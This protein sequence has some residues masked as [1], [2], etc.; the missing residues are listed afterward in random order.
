MAC[1]L[2]ET[3]LYLGDWSPTPLIRVSADAD[4]PCIWSKLEFMNP[5][6][7][8]KDRIASHILTKAYRSGVIAPGGTVV[9]AS[10]GS[11]SIAMA[12]VCAQLGLRFIAVMPAGVSNERSLIIKA[13]G[14]EVYHANASATMGD[15]INEARRLAHEL[16]AFLP[17]QFENPDNAEAHRFGTAREI[18]KQLPTQ[19]V[20]AVV[21]GVGTGGTLVGLYH[22]LRDHGCMAMPVLAKP[23]ASSG[24]ALAAGCFD[25]AECC[26]AYSKRIP[27][28]I[29]NMS[30]LFK[31]SEL[32]GLRTVEIPDEHA[33]ETARGLIRLGFPVGPSS[34]LN[35]AAAVSTYQQL[36]EAGT[37]SPVVVTV[38][39]DRMERYFSTE[40]F[41][42]ARQAGHAACHG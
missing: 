38:F 36:E 16:G 17:A 10:S 31:P 41:S 39:C 23:V 27:G 19:H 6:G 33:I 3:N 9:E 40:L 14:G 12:M 15:C 29:D 26:S 4:G 5:G 13:Y 28:V 20:D 1:H 7:S 35:Y 30:R 34:G 11:T 2:P 24:G 42:P 25:H 22:G 18:I 21:A 37:E 8:T 32:H